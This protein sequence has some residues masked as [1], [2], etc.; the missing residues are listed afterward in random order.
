MTACFL[1]C[2]ELNFSNP[3]QSRTHHTPLR[4]NTYNLCLRLIPPSYIR[5]TIDSCL[6]S[7]P[8]VEVT[9]PLAP[10]LPG[11]CHGSCQDYNGL[12]LWT[13]KPG[14]RKGSETNICLYCFAPS[15]SRMKTIL[16]SSQHSR[17]CWHHSEGAHSH[18]EGAHRN[19]EEGLPSDQCR[20]ESS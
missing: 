8:D 16:S 9:A 10:W 19:S 4:P 7:N 1:A 3:I 11:H 2:P 18:C 12:N 17:K 14:I 5:A 20:T 13:C 15:T 6:L